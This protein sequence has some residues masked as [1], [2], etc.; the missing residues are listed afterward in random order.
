MWAS[1][2]FGLSLVVPGREPLLFP[3]ILGIFSLGNKGD[4]GLYYVDI[5]II[6]LPC[7]EFLVYARHCQAFCL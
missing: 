5:I 1:L 7:I 2:Y 3:F 4:L 6:Q